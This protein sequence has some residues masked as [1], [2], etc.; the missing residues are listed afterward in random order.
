MSKKE[1]SAYSIRRRHGGKLL[2]SKTRDNLLGFVL[3]LPA[4][5]LCVAFILIPIVDSVRM[6]FT[7]YKLVNLTQ[8]IP[9]EWNQFANYIRL[10]SAGKLQ[11]AILLTVRFVVI[12]VSLTFVISLT[13][14][15]LLNGNIKGARILRSVMMIPWV[16]PTVIAGLMW[17]WIYA[18]PYGIV[19]YLV[20]VFSGGAIT[21]FGMLSNKAT[22]MWGVIIAALWKQIPLM[23]LLL[24]AG[25]QNVSDDIIEA[26]KIDGA[27]YFP[28][29][30]HIVLPS[31][32]NVIATVVSMCIIDN[33]K[34]YP[35]FATL[36]NGGPAGATTTLAVLSY[37]EAFVNYN[38]GSG[39]AVT[40]VWLL[41]MIIV[42]FL[43]N[44]VFKREEE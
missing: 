17:A 5:A 20:R 11:S 6:S 41:I 31:M 44:L 32:K 12:T 22:A 33:F 10:W 9:G 16:I 37:D 39:A 4:I 15:L 40:T 35:L 43:F 8:G 19:Q 13:L 36:T 24:I 38:Y 27:G 26:A 21:D 29:L 14:A 34:Q 2:K 18:N 42:V 25:L 7:N 1:N 23:A 30:F 3:L 28:R